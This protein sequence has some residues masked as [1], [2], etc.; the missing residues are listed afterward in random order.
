[1]IGL[2]YTDESEAASFMKVVTKKRSALGERISV[3]RAI[4]RLQ[5]GRPSRLVN[6]CSRGRCHRELSGL[7]TQVCRSTT[8]SAAQAEWALQGV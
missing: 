4:A 2:V 6:L 1:M 8:S 7:C 3:F 5:L